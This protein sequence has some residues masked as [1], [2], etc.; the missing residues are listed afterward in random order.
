MKSRGKKHKVGN[1][2]LNY[3]GCMMTLVEYNSI[4]DIVVE[5][6]SPVRYRVETNLS[7]M[8]KGAIRN[9]YYP[10]VYGV[11]Y[12]GV[13]EYCTIG[14]KRLYKLWQAMLQR[15]YDEKVKSKF[16]TYAR[17]EVVEGWHNF[18]N[19]AKWAIVQ[20]GCLAKG[21]NLDKDILLKGNK[22]YGPDT[23]C[24]VPSEVNMLFI[25]NDKNRSDLPI[26]VSYRKRDNVYQVQMTATENGVRKNIWLGQFRNYQDAFMAY[27]TAKENRIKQVAD[28]WRGIICE[29]VYNAMM[30]YV[31]ELND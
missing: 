6:D 25:K 14:H 5:F 16:P 12:I 31:V 19:F 27:K 10:N 26:G 24:F 7:A 21:W 9:R 23:C 28:L 22:V 30:E 2:Y 8:I 3:Q 29:R 17:C 13:G 20:I 4:K 18:Q 11:G 15:C 1:T